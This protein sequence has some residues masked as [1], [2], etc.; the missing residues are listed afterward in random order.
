MRRTVRLE[1]ERRSIGDTFSNDESDGLLALAGL[2]CIRKGRTH[3]AEEK[4]AGRIE[5]VLAS[6]EEDNAYTLSAEALDDGLPEAGA[7]LYRTAAGDGA[8]QVEVNEEAQETLDF[9]ALCGALQG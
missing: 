2:L 5:I 3:G 7:V 1:D 9:I 6:D 8:V 4:R